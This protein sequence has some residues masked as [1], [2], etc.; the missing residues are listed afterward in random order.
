M[1]NITK[2]TVNQEDDTLS[3]E[4]M[5][6]IVEENRLRVRSFSNLAVTVCSLFFSTSFIILFFIQEKMKVGHIKLLYFML[7]LVN[8]IMIAAIAFATLVAYNKEP[9]ALATKTGTILHQAN[10][11]RHEHRYAYIALI[12]MLIGLSVFLLTMGL[13]AFSISLNI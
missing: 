13:Y 10:L 5:L 6:R 7:I 4:D 11:Y 1:L 12:L 8:V 2:H 9:H 3:K